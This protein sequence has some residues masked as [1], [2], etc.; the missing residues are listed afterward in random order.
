MGAAFHALL[1]KLKVLEKSLGVWDRG[2]YVRPNN[3]LEQ[4]RRYASEVSG[5]GE[6]QP[7][8]SGGSW[9]GV[10]LKSNSLESVNGI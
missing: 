4:T 3:D 7:R 6:C 2:I 8:L 5:L 10:Q 9:W 1:S